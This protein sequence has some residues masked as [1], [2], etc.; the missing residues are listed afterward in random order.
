MHREVA[1][2]VVVCALAFG[3]GPALAQDR[4]PTEEQCYYAAQVCAEYINDNARFEQCRFEV[5]M[6]D[7]IN[8]PGRGDPTPPRPIDPPRPGPGYEWCSNGRYSTN[9][10]D[11][12]ARIEPISLTSGL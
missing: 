4:G 6:G 5:A 1:S 11:E 10:D 7:C 9:C 3:A 8:N 12:R 2:A